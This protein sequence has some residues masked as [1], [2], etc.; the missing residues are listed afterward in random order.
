MGPLV[1]RKNSQSGGCERGV[2]WRD[3]LDGREGEER[4]VKKDFWYAR[5]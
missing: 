1:F 5:L 2:L 4:V 3:K